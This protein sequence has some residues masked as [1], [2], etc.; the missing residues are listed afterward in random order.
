MA[1]SSDQIQA[2]IAR[3]RA[4]IADRL[5]H[6]STG[7]T[8]GKASG[9]TH[10]S[11]ST[12]GE[13]PG[14]VDQVRQRPMVALGLALIG[15]SLLQEYLSDGSTTHAPG[16]GGAMGEGRT[17]GSGRYN[18]GES[19]LGATA[20]AAASRVAGAA[21]SAGHTVVDTAQTVGH[22]V[23]D[24]AQGVVDTARDAASTVAETT[25]DVAQ[26]VA[27]TTGDVAEEVWDTTGDIASSVIEQVRRRPFMA[28]GISLAAGALLQ[29]YRS[30]SQ[31]GHRYSRTTGH[32]STAY[33]TT[34]GYAMGGSTAR[35]TASHAI[36]RVGDAAQA[37]GQAV[38]DVAGSVG[39]TVSGV[40]H[41]VVDTARDAASAVVET[42]GDVAQR[43]AGSAA[44]AAEHVSET[45]S[46]LTWQ[47]QERP[48]TALALAVGAGM[49]LRPTLAP[50]VGAVTNDVRETV[51]SFSSGVGELIRLPAPADLPRVQ[52]AL[53]PA[54]VDR[55]RQLINH[56]V[57][58]Y[59]DRSLEGL[60][61]QKT[62]RAGVVA[63]ITEKT[64]KVVENQL[65]RRLTALSGTPALL[66]LA[67]AGALLS[68]R[69]Q[70]QTQQSSSASTI[71]EQ[72]AETLLRDAQEQLGRFFPEFRQELQAQESTGKQ[73][74]N[75]GAR[76]SPGTRFCPDCGQAVSAG[77]SL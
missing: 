30:G 47:V 5:D 70:V 28:L 59:L 25:G 72:L 67:L 14:L 31:P 74:T 51:R 9:G 76:L 20:S 73:C 69:N 57:R 42:T 21:Q 56:E 11:I 7:S 26:R 37:T 60:L 63:T 15:G 43:A 17:A 52:Q 77:T 29:N 38:S 27:E 13:S 40:A 22:T 12:T 1:Q 50:H 66:A 19:T 49:L 71:R 54:T 23:V 41:G 10:A 48:L 75:C 35:S 58:D 39:Q 32:A 64:E 36:D 6:I 16:F 44:G 45:F 68:A 24:T 8:A 2:D 4:R 46:D 18:D 33:D 53:V 62:L 34:H 55:S 61:E 3:T 65:T